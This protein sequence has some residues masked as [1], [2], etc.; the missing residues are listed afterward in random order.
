MPLATLAELQRINQLCVMTP[1]RTPQPRIT[2]AS[3]DAQL[4]LTRTLASATQQPLNTQFAWFGDARPAVDVS[5]DL[6]RRLLSLYGQFVDDDGKRVDYASMKASPEFAEYTV[7]AA[8]LQAVRVASLPP[9]ERLAFF[10]NIYNSLII[11]AKAVGVRGDSILFRRLSFFD[12]AAY[13]VDGWDLSANDIE[14]GILRANAP[15][16]GVL[17]RVLRRPWW[18]GGDPRREALSLA[19]VDP[20]IH[21]ALN[22]GANSCPAI[23]VY[24][25][26][27]I[28][29]ALEAAARGFVRAEVV[30]VSENVVELSK[31]FDWYGRDFAESDQA[32]LQRIEGWAEGGTLGVQPG[33]RLVFREYDWGDNA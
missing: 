27:N 15:A 18:W 5:K 26:N 23:R 4:C 7:A 1:R 2:S 3:Q 10:I 17:G 33:A 12:T 28:D 20:R 22:C 24:D 25:G 9:P 31:I 21:F 32:L 13:R 30:K 16:P 11:H 8:E 29:A 19:T 14:H 6:R